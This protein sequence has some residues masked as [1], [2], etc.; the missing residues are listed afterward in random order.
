MRPSNAIGEAISNAIAQAFTTSVACGDPNQNDEGDGYS[1]L[2]VSVAVAIASSETAGE[3]CL[4]SADAV[5]EAVSD[6]VTEGV[7]GGLLENTDSKEQTL[8]E[9]WLAEESGTISDKI[10]QAATVRQ[11]SGTCNLV[12]LQKSLTTASEV[13][14][15]MEDAISQILRAV[16]CG[17]NF[18]VD[19]PEGLVSLPPETSLEDGV[20]DEAESGAEEAEVADCRYDAEKRRFFGTCEP[21][22]KKGPGCNAQ[23]RTCRR[24]GTANKQC[25]AELRACSRDGLNKAKAKNPRKGK[26]GSNQND[27]KGGNGN[28]EKSQKGQGQNKGGNGR[29]SGQGRRR[30]L[31]SGKN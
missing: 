6:M 4:A 15:A 30:R 22:E 2:A 19:D 17:D 31:R 9:A 16:N 3:E 28:S 11:Q 12:G 13:G 8:A 27:R 23:F 5:A 21:R 26:G 1:S 25:H 29:P 7:A 24:S 10:Q 18:Q 14:D 20:L